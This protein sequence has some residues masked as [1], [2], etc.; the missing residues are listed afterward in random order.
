MPNSYDPESY[1]GQGTMP[2]LYTKAADGSVGEWTVWSIGDEVCTEWGKVGGKMQQS[3]FKCEA[4]NVGR[5]N[6]TTPEQQAI[7]EAISQWKKKRKKK[8]FLTSE[9]ASAPKAP[10]PMLAKSGKEAKKLEE[11]LEEGADVQPK[12][13]GLRC[14]IWRKDE[15]TDDGHITL[16]SRGNDEYNVQHIEW[17][18]LPF[19]SSDIVLD[20]EL[21]AHGVSLQ[22]I[23]SLARRPQEDSVQLTYVI[24]DFIR[25]QQP[26]MEWRQRWEEL[27]SWH[28]SLR[29]MG[30]EDCIQLAQTEHVRS[31][32]DV[33]RWH[34]AFVQAG[35]E[36]AIIRFS[37]GRYR[38]GYRSS[39]LLKWKKF[40]DAEFPIVGYT[41]GKGK[42]SEFPVFRCVTGEGRGFDVMPMG[43]EEQRRQ[44]LI[45]APNF[46]GKQLTVR[47][48][49]WTDERIPHFP[50]GVAIRPEGT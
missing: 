35:Y 8:Y 32:A 49:D 7:L 1:Q 18:L 11:K 4:K 34:D 22:T 43:T 16:Q 42:F 10:R 30:L 48:F 44:M 3:S 27:K 25:K 21:Y 31:V 15:D 28:A 26:D 29:S 19:L 9:E 36:G 12:Y 13:D 23:T 46:I 40:Q 17:A 6:A 33:E 39:E 5:A 50:V 37:H 38:F 14:L 47:F 45:D 2:T 20:G 24:Y 41:N